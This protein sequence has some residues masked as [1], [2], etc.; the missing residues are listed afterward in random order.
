MNHDPLIEVF[1]S[2]AEFQAMMKAAEQNNKN[3]G[4]RIRELEKETT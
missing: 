3:I 2:D 1:Q 4:K